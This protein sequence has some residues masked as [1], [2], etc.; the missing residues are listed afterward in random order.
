MNEPLIERTLT[1]IEIRQ[2]QVDHLGVLAEIDNYRDEMAE[3]RRCV[4]ESAAEI[5]RLEQRERQL[6]RELRS[7]TVLEAR[8]RTLEYADTQRE[9]PEP[10][11]G[12]SCDPPAPSKFDQLYPVARNRVDLEQDLLAMGYALDT[13]M[14]V[15]LR[16]LHPDSGKFEA[17]AHWARI[18]RARNEPTE[19]PVA[20]LY[21]PV[22]PPIPEA[23]NEIVNAGA[24]VAAK[25]SRKKRGAR[26]LANGSKS[27]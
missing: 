7:G 17:I 4:K 19:A 8:Q 11:E 26:P 3:H 12:D 18:G 20:G 6:R 21:I 25:V 2:R 9:R 10:D 27:A 1:P 13:A 14:A 15:A 24:P 22:S 16:K 23:W 5:E